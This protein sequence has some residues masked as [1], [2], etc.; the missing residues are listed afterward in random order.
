[1][2]S[3]NNFICGEAQLE[4]ETLEEAELLLKVCKENDID[5][6]HIKPEYF[7]DEPYWYVRDGW[8]LEITRYY[9]DDDQ[10]CSAWTVQEFI[11]NHTR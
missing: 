4:C 5:C 9:C 3:W 6:D 1:M 7:K 8:T 2:V 10:I 11:E